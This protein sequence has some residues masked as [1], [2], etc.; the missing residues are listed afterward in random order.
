MLAVSLY[1]MPS[2]YLQ[3]V[4]LSWLLFTALQK[5]PNSKLATTLV[6][7]SLFSLGIGSVIKQSV[8]EDSEMDDDLDDPT[9]VILA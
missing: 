3:F 9:E 5:D 7:V 4:G 6:K 1:K 2:T 8:P